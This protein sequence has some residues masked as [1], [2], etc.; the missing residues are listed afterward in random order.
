MVAD[1]TSFPMNLLRDCI[2]PTREG[3]T[4]FGD[5]WYRAI[6]QIPCDWIKAPTGP[7]PDRPESINSSL[8]GGVDTGIPKPD[9]GPN[10]VQVTPKETVI[11]AYMRAY[12]GGPRV[13]NA[14]PHWQG[15]GMIA[16]GLGHMGD[17]RYKKN[18]VEAGK[19]ADGIHRDAK[20]V[21][22]VPIYLSV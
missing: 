2:H 13:C 9:W 6:K 16:T 11:E 14:Y 15:T 5:Y 8:N 21:R 1:F 3:Y 4:V 12:T 10:P 22:S 17:W 19:V 7:D 20:Y 18:W